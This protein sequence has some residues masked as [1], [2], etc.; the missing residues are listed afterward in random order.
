MAHNPP[1]LSKILAYVPSLSYSLLSLTHSGL[2]FLRLRLFIEA[3]LYT[4]PLQVFV[5][6]VHSQVEVTVSPD[7]I[8]LFDYLTSRCKRVNHFKSGVR[9]H[10]DCLVGIGG[11]VL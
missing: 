6:F 10:P 11:E 1:C 9:A 2:V 8:E 3:E 5:Q 7:V 4:K